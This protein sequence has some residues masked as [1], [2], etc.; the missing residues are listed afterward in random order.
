V[1][2]A[3]AV[4]LWDRLIAPIHARPTEQLAITKMQ[5]FSFRKM[6]IRQAAQTSLP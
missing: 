3:E 1:S 6:N 5:F 2:D 4:A